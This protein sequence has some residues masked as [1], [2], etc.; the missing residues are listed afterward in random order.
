MRPKL[1]DLFC[2]AGLGTRGYAA[3]FDMTGVDIAPQ[4]NY[5]FTFVQ[6]DALEYVAAHGHEYDIIHASPVCKGYSGAGVLAADNR[7]VYDLAISQVRSIL[8]GIGKPYIIENVEGARWD[9]HAPITLC[10]SMWPELRVYR[11][12]LFET[13]PEI[14]LTPYHAP[15]DDRTP[16]AGRGRSPKGFMSITSGGITGV[17]MAERFAAMGH[18]TVCATNKELNESFPP[19]FCEYIGARMIELMQ[20]QAAT[21]HRVEAIREMLG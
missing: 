9:M 5:P 14:M 6:A 15:H 3:Y 2:G 21:A 17:T 4:P 18:S 12:R 19:Q 8:R 20:M 1:L 11:H 13:W 10:G 16:P 7:K